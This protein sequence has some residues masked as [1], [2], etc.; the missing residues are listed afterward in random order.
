MCRTANQI[1][2]AC[3]DAQAYPGQPETLLTE[4]DAALVLT[5]GRKLFCTF[6]TYGY[7]GRT[8][9]VTRATIS[10]GAGEIDAPLSDRA[11]DVVH[12]IANF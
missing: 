12:Q 7:E 8:R 2:E 4:E 5:D 6:R 9:Q 11:E 3:N 10:F 1:P